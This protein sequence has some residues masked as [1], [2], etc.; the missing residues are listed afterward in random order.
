MPGRLLNST[1]RKEDKEKRKSTFWQEVNGRVANHA[2]EQEHGTQ[3]RG[4][5]GC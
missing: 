4:R 5:W 3:N 1:G 2:T